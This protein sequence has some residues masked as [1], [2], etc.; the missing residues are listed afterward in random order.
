[1]ERE[2]E[3]SQRRRDVAKLTV[4]SYYEE[5]MRIR[6]LD[7]QVALLK[8]VDEALRDSDYW[9]TTGFFSSVRGDN[10]YDHWLC[11]A[12]KEWAASH[13]PDGSQQ[14]DGWLSETPCGCAM[15]FA[16]TVESR[17]W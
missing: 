15:R 16:S 10:Y 7:E 8:A 5:R 3:R 4:T 6:R 12:I 11:L 13:E 1:M 9:R 17:I 14:W 2:R